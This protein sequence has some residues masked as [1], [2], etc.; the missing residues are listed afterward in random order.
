VLANDDPTIVAVAANGVLTNTDV[1]VFDRDDVSALS[2]FI[3]RHCKLYGE[4]T[5]V[6]RAGKADAAAIQ[7][8]SCD[9]YAKWIPIIGRK[10][11]PMMVDY[12]T[13]VVDHWI[14]VIEHEEAIVGLV[15]MIPRSD[16]LFIENLAVA[17]HMQ[18]KGLASRLL[19]HA[20]TLTRRCGLPEVQLA[21]NQAFADN[22]MFYENRGYKVYETKPFELGGVGVRFRKS[23]S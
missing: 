16:H 17:K 3:I 15:E 6:R 4:K 9:V 7:K 18:G 11:K 14:D 1:P 2:Q 19:L 20:E 13:A 12:D 5:T 8:L 23:V 22:L 21:T 10:P